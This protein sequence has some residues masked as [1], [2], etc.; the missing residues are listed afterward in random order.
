MTKTK[1]P[2]LSRIH[3]VKIADY[4][5]DNELLIIE[6]KVIK[7]HL[8]KMDQ[9]LFRILVAAGLLVL[10]MFLGYIFWGIPYQYGRALC[11]K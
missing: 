7:A 11:Q 1:D 5:S 8:D 6:A 9:Q 10:F 2:K 4:Y 3:S